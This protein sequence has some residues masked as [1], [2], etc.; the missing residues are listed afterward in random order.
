[1]ENSIG[2]VKRVSQDLNILP[3]APLSVSGDSVAGIIRAM[4]RSSRLSVIRQVHHELFLRSSVNFVLHPFTYV[5]F[6]AHNRSCDKCDN[7][8]I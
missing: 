2:I 3:S 6:F 8:G 5:P 4:I 7:I 1:M